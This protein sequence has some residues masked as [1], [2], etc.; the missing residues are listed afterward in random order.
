MNE[1]SANSM[2]VAGNTRDL[3]VSTRSLVDAT[4]LDIQFLNVL[5]KRKDELKSESEKIIESFKRLAE[6][7]QKLQTD[8]KFVN[9]MIISVFKNMGEKVN[10]SKFKCTCNCYSE[11]E[12]N[13]DGKITKH[14]SN[15]H[16][17]SKY[18]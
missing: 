6:V 14:C 18:A 1:S 13:R 16:K 10:V 12:L 2:D 3:V 9:N 7:W 11:Y 5:W 17:I 8:T 15:C 4:S